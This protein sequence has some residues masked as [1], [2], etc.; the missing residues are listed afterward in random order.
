MLSRRLQPAVAQFHRSSDATVST[1]SASGH[2]SAPKAGY[3]APDR[4]DRPSPPFP[5]CTGL[6]AR[7]RV[8]QVQGL[9]PSNLPLWDPRGDLLTRSDEPLHARLAG[10][11][12][13][14]RQAGRKRT[15]TRN[16][17]SEREIGRASC[18]ERV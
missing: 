10:R 4:A 1:R 17:H 6:S 8:A 2:A 12:G 16:L 5:P 18:R 11:N 14:L 9:Q 3:E 7:Y 15:S 13:V